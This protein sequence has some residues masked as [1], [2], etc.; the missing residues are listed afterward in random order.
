MHEAPPVVY[1][2]YFVLAGSFLAI[3]IL[4]RLANRKRSINQSVSLLFLSVSV[5]AVAAGS[6]HA[7]LDTRGSFVRPA[8]AASGLMIASL[9]TLWSCIRRSAKDFRQVLHRNR[10]VYLAAVIYAL[11][12]FSPWFIPYASTE[13]NPMHGELRNVLQYFL[14]VPVVTMVFQMVRERRNLIGSARFEANFLVIGSSITICLVLLRN[15]F[16]DVMPTDIS[17]AWSGILGGVFLAVLLYGMLTRR[18]LDSKVLAVHATRFALTLATTLIAIE[19]VRRGLSIATVSPVLSHL[20]TGIVAV[21][22]WSI[23]RQTFSR[24]WRNRPSSEFLDLQIKISR[25]GDSADSL[26]TCLHQIEALV[27]NSLD[28]S[29]CRVAVETESGWVSADPDVSVPADCELILNESRWAN[30]FSLERSWQ[31]QSVEKLTAWL[32]SLEVETA[33]MSPHQPRILILVGEHRNRKA[34]TFSEIDELLSLADVMGT[35]IGRITTAQKNQER[36]KMAALPMVAA[37]LGHDLK[38]Y[39][40]SFQLFAEIMENHR[41]VPNFVDRHL[42]RYRQQVDR[43][44]SLSGQL[45]QLGRPR[46]RNPQTRPLE[47]L[48]MELKSE[49]KP[50]ADRPE[51]RVHWQVTGDLG[52]FR[53]D[54]EL[55]ARALRNLCLNA[56]EALEGQQRGTLRISLRRTGQGL[57]IEVTDSGPGL[58]EDIRQQLFEP[59]VSSRK[60]NGSGLG[61]YL[62]WDSVVK[63]G[64]KITYE[65]VSPHGTRFHLTLPEIN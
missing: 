40:A 56:L 3:A 6:I 53:T 31:S 41:E 58:P 10:F 61:I 62:A 34:H 51:I 8:V 57:T 46:P 65:D 43:L 52:K 29:R 20:L 21:S 15:L 60:A 37:G 54:F 63:L 39:T 16:R 35:A 17:P 64:G 49:I 24:I 42:P 50:R 2:L 23:G 47:A 44:K 1:G 4:V 7:G 27:S 48:V 55:L 45:S 59:F 5:W 19:V 12:V 9:W 25:L 32:T 14:F 13:V 28:V 33:I 30:L 26:P 36:G 22:V 38:Q 18:I 11:L